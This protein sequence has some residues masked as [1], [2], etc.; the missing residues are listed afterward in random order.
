MAGTTEHP[1]C[2]CC[3]MCAR[4]KGELLPPEPS[5]QNDCELI[6]LQFVPIR[7]NKEEILEIKKSTPSSQ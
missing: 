4:H 2:N 6:E 1:Q 7:T 5:R 3:S